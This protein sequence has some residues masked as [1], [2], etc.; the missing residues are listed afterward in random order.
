MADTVMADAPATN[1]GVPFSLR[2]RFKISDLPLVKDK[3]LAIDALLL[4]FKK[5]GGYDSL[6]KQVWASYN[7][8]DAKTALTDQIHAIAEAEIEK[9]PNLLT[10]E[11]GKA[12]T[13][14]QGAVDRS[15]IYQDVESRID[16]EIAKHLGT[17]L[18]A[19]RE[20]R[21]QEVGDEVAAEEEQRG[22]K[23]DE[24]YK[25]ETENRAAER[26]RNRARMEQLLRETAELKAKIKQE[27]ERKRKK[28]EAKREEEERKKR[29][30][31][32]EE[33]KAARAKR[34]EEEEKREAERIKAREERHRKREEERQERYARYEKERERERDHDRERDRDRGR[35][36]ERERDRD[37]DRERRRSVDR[38][39]SR[40]EPTHA[41]D[42]QTDEKDLEATAL[43]LLLKTGYMTALEDMLDQIDTPENEKDR[44]TATDVTTI[45][46]AGLVTDEDPFRKGRRL[47]LL[48]VDLQV[49]TAKKAKLEVNET[50]HPLFEKNTQPE[51]EDLALLHR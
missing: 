14:I 4:K 18:D 5:Q 35:D 49:E 33:R 38:R 29:E 46:V 23:T 31:E 19:V 37:R 17:V 28:E 1:S 15:G 42:A 30:A 47:I 32:E 12:A 50:L 36:R 21:R 20:I 34:R 40:E 22:S 7:T 51:K 24:Q 13:L 41:R 2:T 16:T 8:S 6:R 39:D 43:E 44:A 10:R 48:A 27:E 3:R 11:R 25:A 45:A 9:D 26:E